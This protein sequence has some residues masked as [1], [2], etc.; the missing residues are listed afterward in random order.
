MTFQTAVEL[1][2][3]VEILLVED[4]AADVWLTTEH[5]KK[6]KTPNLVHVAPDGVA[7]MA[8]FRQ[9]GEYQSAARPDLVLL[10]LNLPRKSGHEVLAE[11]KGDPALASIPVVVLTTSEAEADV[12]RSYNLH[13]NCFITKPIDLEQFAKV[14]TALEDYWFTIVRLPS[15]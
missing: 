12:V 4:N 11:L 14:L 3:P 13:A 6:F 15:Q 8:Y 10:D 9:Q 7:A 5:L 1:G 2:R